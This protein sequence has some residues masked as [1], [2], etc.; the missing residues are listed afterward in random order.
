M[1]SY[2]Y[3]VTFRKR[4]EQNWDRVRANSKDDAITKIKQIY[5]Y[6]DLI[7]VGVSRIGN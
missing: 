1:N 7:P 2:L 3:E 4:G 5:G 6:D